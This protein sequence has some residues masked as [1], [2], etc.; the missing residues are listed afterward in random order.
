MDR[1][2]HRVK[3]ARRN[4]LVHERIGFAAGDFFFVVGEI[5][6]FDPGGNLEALQKFRRAARHLGF[7]GA[8]GIP[9]HAHER[10]REDEAGKRRV[11]RA[12]H[13]AG[14]VGKRH[15]AAEAMAKEEARERSLQLARLHEVLEPGVDILVDLFEGSEVA[16]GAGRAAMAAQVDHVYVEAEAAGLLDHFLVAAAMLAEAVDN[17][18]RPARIGRAEA[19]EENGGPVT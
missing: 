14:R 2:L 12:G 4:P 17:E 15:E 7:E 6:E 19:F 11:E 1:A 8:G 13:V 10:R 3:A 5:L 18:K 9:L 16:A